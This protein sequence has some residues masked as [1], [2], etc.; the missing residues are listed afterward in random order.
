M[1]I[2][3]PATPLFWRIYKTT[4]AFARATKTTATFTTVG[5]ATSFLRKTRQIDKATPLEGLKRGKHFK[6]L[7]EHNKDQ[8]IA[9]KQKKR[10]K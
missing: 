8:Q 9:P 1:T 3:R 7:P 6:P 10:K 5:S 4:A 2:T